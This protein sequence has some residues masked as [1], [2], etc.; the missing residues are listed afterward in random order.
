MN[1]IPF[2]LY[3]VMIINELS[4]YRRNR[5]LSRNIP[6]AAPQVNTA[7]RGSDCCFLLDNGEE[8]G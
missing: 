8:I 7:L 4:A 5:L 2:L 6:E 3:Y 1:S